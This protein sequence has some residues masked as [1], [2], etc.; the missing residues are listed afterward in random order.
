MK[1]GVRDEY[2]DDLPGHCKEV[3]AKR[4][5]ARRVEVRKF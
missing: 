1:K 4:L 3:Q 5:N 2:D